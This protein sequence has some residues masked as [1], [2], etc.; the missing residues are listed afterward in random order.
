VRK[1]ETGEQE[2][3]LVVMLEIDVARVLNIQKVLVHVKLD[4]AQAK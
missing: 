1:Q 4:R 3:R 2:R